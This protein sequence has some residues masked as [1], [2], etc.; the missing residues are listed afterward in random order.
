MKLS[1]EDTEII[2]SFEGLSLVSYICPAG[3]YTCGFGCTGPDI[4]EGTVWTE[5][6]CRERFMEEIN[7]L[8]DK[9]EKA[10]PS[11]IS[12]NK[13]IAIVSLTYNIGLPSFLASTMLK[14]LKLA[15]W[16]GAA[17]EILRWDK[18]TVSG[19]KIM[20]KGLHSRRK[21]EQKLF[22]TP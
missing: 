3:V 19:K 1:F 9:L 21:L 13:F 7:R 2:R 20:S 18:I 5:E 8:C 14:K 15:D 17:E 6:Y 4:V 10:L 11:N 22:L 12:K 16:G